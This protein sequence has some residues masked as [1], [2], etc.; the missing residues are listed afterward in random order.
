MKKVAILT[1]EGFEEVELTSPKAALEQAGY[2]VDILSP[3]EGPIKSW[4][5]TDWGGTFNVDANVNKTQINAADYEALVL[6]GGVINPD[7]LRECQNSMNLIKAFNESGKPI[8]AI[9]H[10]PQS[11]IEADVIKGKNITSYSSIKKDLQNAGANWQDQ[12]VV[13]DGNLITS[14]NPDDLHA[15]NQAIIEAIS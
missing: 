15:F 14:R 3:Q 10:G 13:K 12:E 5:H 2:Q 6:P 7:K 8:A 4:Q 11:L 9:C 1:A